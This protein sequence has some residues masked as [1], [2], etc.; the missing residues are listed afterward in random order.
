[1]SECSECFKVFKSNKGLVHHLSFCKTLQERKFICEFCNKELSSKVSLSNHLSVCKE[2][3]TQESSSNCEK[4]SEDYKLLLEENRALKESI[5]KIERENR[6]L[7]SEKENL[8]LEK[9]DLLK[10]ISA[11]EEIISNLNIS[12]KTINTVANKVGNTFNQTNINNNTLNYLKPITKDDFEKLTTNLIDDHDIVNERLFAKYCMQY[13]LKNKVLKT[14]HARKVLTYFDEEGK[15]VKDPKAKELTENIYK[16]TK[17]A[18]E[19]KAKQYEKFN[20]EQDKDRLDFYNNVVSINKESMAKFSDAIVNEA[21]K[22]LP[23]ACFNKIF[24]FLKDEVKKSAYWL[25]SQ[26]SI[27]IGEWIRD[28]LDNKIQICRA[29]VSIKNKY[30]IIR[31]GG[32]KIENKELKEGLKFAMNI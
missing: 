17:T 13:G 20:D 25:F 7:K 26:D 6:F 12:I 27:S 10:T 5:Q 31:E 3:K 19:E 22:T 14:D 24:L 30:I 9:K 28:K 11:K 16:S 29:N 18:F 21:N 1:M 23:S 32:E 8:T 2:R 15:Q 4:M